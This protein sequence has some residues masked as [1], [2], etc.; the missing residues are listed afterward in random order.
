VQARF[1]SAFG[2]IAPKKKFTIM[3]VFASGV[4]LYVSIAFG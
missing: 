2:V 4:T 3:L 1:I